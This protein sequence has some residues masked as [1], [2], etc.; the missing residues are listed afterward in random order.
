MRLLVSSFVICGCMCAFTG[1]I[2]AQEKPTNTMGDIS[3]NTGIVTQGQIG[4]NYVV[5]YKAPTISIVGSVPPTRNAAGTY[6]LSLIFRIVSQS[7]ANSLIV[8]VRE[9]DIV[10]GTAISGES[11]NVF[12]R[13][14]GVTMMAVG[15]SNGYLWR[16]IQTPS[17]G[18]Y[19]LKLK[20]RT[21]EVKPRIQIG[22]E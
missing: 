12:P 17:A 19:E 20:V 11:L 14:G 22:V 21:A 10:P 8:A 7:P 5:Q 15:N 13:G 2:V 3:N 4:D 18:E 9:D 1:E 16:K 6:D